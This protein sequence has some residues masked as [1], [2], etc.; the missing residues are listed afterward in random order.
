MSRLGAFSVAGVVVVGLLLAG[1]PVSAQAESSKDLKRIWDIY[2]RGCVD[3][4]DGSFRV[5]IPR[6][7]LAGV[8]AEDDILARQCNLLI[9]YEVVFRPARDG[10]DG[11][12]RDGQ[13][14]IQGPAGPIGPPGPIGPKG[15]PGELLLPP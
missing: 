3:R 9:E 10:E 7:V 11:S 6:L 15:D 8:S 4:V 1:T 13:A 12:S 2:L 14:G 5:Y